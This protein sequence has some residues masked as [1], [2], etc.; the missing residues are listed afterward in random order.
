MVGIRE[1]A[2]NGVV[3]KI[4]S[5][6]RVW[7]SVGRIVGKAEYFELEVLLENPSS[8]KQESYDADTL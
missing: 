4:C 5:L 2:S 8:S 6:D 1:P 7:I 3:S